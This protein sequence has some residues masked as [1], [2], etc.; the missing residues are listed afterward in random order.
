VT[1]AF[2]GYL[3]SGDED[4]ASYAVNST[5]FLIPQ[6]FSWTEALRQGAAARTRGQSDADSQVG[7]N[8]S[9]SGRKPFGLA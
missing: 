4:E 1:A 6:C 9:S 2:A 8:C 5:L 3:T 7:S